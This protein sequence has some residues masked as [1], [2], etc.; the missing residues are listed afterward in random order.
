MKRFAVLP[1]LAA[2]FATTPARAVA[3]VG[4]DKP[5][6]VQE[7]YVFLHHDE[8]AKRV[9]IL[10]AARVAPAFRR[11]TMGIPTPEY[12]T[13]HRMAPHLPDVLHKLIAPHE[14][15]L[16]KHA[17]VPPAPWIPEGARFDSF[18]EGADSADHVFDAAWTKSYVD[19][20]FFIAALGVTTPEDGRL[21]VMSPT[22]HISFA[23]ERLVLARREPRLPMPEE[24]PDLDLPDKPRLPVEVSVSKVEPRQTGLTAESITRLLSNRPGELLTCYEHFLERRPNTTVTL[25]LKT[26][27]RPKG[28]VVSIKWVDPPKDLQTKELGACMT[29]VLQSKALPKADEGYEFQSSIVLTP[30]RIPARRTHIV[31]IGSSKHVWRDV[32]ASVKL[33]EDF[34]IL[35]QDV[36]LAMTA[37][38]RK[39]L[40]MRNGERVWVSHWLDRSVRRTEA[41]DVEFERQELP[42]RGEAGALP[43]E[44]HDA[45]VDRPKRME[46]V[47][48]GQTS[49]R[50]R[51]NALAMLGMLVLSL[52]AAL[53][54]AGREM[55]G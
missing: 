16:G 13:I 32:P 54:I 18:V 30:P 26:T 22:T 29:K 3:V 51:R 31:T 21:E 5:V 25:S 33:V 46:N 41:A 2:S 40:G 14:M 9:H 27:V 24:P 7:D 50:K 17:P 15:R 28:D 20:G 39:L 52:A 48:A 4:G 47:S 34:E 23:S 53:G 43:P 8:A 36:E 38:T 12:P 44:V 37:E 11:V 49:S 19:K 6:M 45:D 55:R 42:A 10:F 35:P 1:V